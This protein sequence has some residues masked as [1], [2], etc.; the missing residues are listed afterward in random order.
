LP[1]RQE[2]V[3]RRM[4]VF[5]SE[6]NDFS[7]SDSQEFVQ[8]RP[9]IAADSGGQYDPRFSNRGCPNTD[10]FGGADSFADFLVSGFGQR[11]GHDGG[12]IQDHR[13]YRLLHA[14]GAEAEDFLLCFFRKP[15]AEN[16]FGIPG[17]IRLSNSDCNLTFLDGEPGHIFRRACLSSSARRIVSVLVSLVSRA[18]SFTRVSSSGFLIFNPIYTYR[19]IL[20]FLIAR[21]PIR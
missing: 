8:F 15:P 11:D 7:V 21:E 6:R 13:G 18:I 2:R 3:Q 17:Q 12:G 9:G 5:E 20:P 4:E 14:R 16:F 19:I 10:Y 1:N